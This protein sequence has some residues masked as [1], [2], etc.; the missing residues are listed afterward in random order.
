MSEK[1]SCEQDPI[2]DGLHCE[3][4]AHTS[5]P[6]LEAE[7]E[8]ATT[9]A[10]SMSRAGAADSK[11]SDRDRSKI[12]GG[13]GAVWARISSQVCDVVHS[14]LSRAQRVHRDFFATI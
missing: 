2:A 14:P 5:G 1:L 11:T 3:R 8:M 12:F 9:E 13:G 6:K 4:L 7:P 10:I